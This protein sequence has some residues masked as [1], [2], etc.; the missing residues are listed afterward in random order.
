MP[1]FLGWILEVSTVPLGPHLT[2][3]GVSGQFCIPGILNQLGTPQD[4]KFKLIILN[5]KKEDQ[6][7]I[8]KKNKP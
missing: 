7:N 6:L 1:W 5:S 3:Q 4:P 2:I 8:L